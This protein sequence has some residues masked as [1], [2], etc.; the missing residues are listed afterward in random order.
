MGAIGV[1][2]GGYNGGSTIIGAGRSST[3]D[4]DFDFKV[5]DKPNGRSKSP[6][7][8]FAQKPPAF[9]I[10]GQPISKQ[11]RRKHRMAQLQNVDRDTVLA[12][13]ERS[14]PKKLAE[15]REALKRLVLE[16][17]LL[18]TGAINIGHPAVAA[19]LKSER[20][21]SNKHG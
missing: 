9:T 19:W 3:F 5:A 2:R 10:A 13:L 8:K 11:V 16:K 20:K 17:I 6:P 14:L 18:Q 1:G 4:P 21:K 15:R 7:R 12:G